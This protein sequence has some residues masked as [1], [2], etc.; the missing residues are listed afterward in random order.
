MT[1][2]LS[3]TNVRAREAPTV[4]I[5][6]LALNSNGAFKI[7]PFGSLLKKAEL[8]HQGIPVVGIENVLPNQFVK[9]FR[10]FITD[11]KFNELADY[12]ILKDDILVTTMGTIGR[13]A[14]AP[15]RLGSAIIDSHLF[16]M[17][18][19]VNRI[20]PEYLCYAINSPLVIRQLMREARGAIMDGLNTTILRE[21]SVPLPP[22]SAQRETVAVLTRADHLRRMRSYALQMSD[23]LLPAT[24]L[25]LFG[26][27][28]IN[29]LGWEEA[30]IEDVLEWS[31]YGTS[32]RSNNTGKGYPVLGM[33]NLSEDGHINLSPLAYVDLP[34]DEF[35]S[36]KL[37]PGDVIFNRTNSTE[38]VGKTACWRHNI[39]AVVASYLVRLRLVGRQHL[40]DRMS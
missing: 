22:I 35:E 8:V 32:Q 36:L 40:S 33:A 3:L 9:D 21:C 5:G 26:D 2:N 29:P 16:R 18:V 27:P 14:V 20:L 34:A 13:A 11:Q 38:L 10:R 31:Q 19:D 39:D 28:R 4:A 37:E 1:A 12:E 7:G 23:E 30:T 25:R 15:G 24:F 6:D 17:R